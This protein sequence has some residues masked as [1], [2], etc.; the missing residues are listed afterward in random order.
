MGHF[1]STLCSLWKNF[2]GHFGSTSGL[3]RKYLRGYCWIILV[4]FWNHC[5]GCFESTRG[6]QGKYLRG[7]CGIFWALF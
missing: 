3:F 5:K 4:S 2:E 6:S 7:H 1:V